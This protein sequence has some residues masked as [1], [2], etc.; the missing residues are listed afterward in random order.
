MI[1]KKKR[2]KNWE[3]GEETGRVKHVRH[4]EQ[5]ILVLPKQNRQ[6]KNCSL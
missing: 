3:S 5:R 4:L 1:E 6:R 2:K